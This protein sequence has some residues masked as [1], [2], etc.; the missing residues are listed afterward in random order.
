[1]AGFRKRGAVWYYRYRDETGRQIEAKGCRDLG[2]TKRLAHAAEDRARAIKAGLID[3]REAQYAEAERRPLAEHVGDWHRALIARGR[4]KRYA[5]L[6][7]DYVLRLIGMAKATRIGQLTPSGI[8]IALGDLSL[9]PGRCGN[10]GLSDRSVFHHARAGKM[11]AKWLWKDGRARE[12]RLAHLTAPKVVHARRRAALS[13]EDGAR[14]IAAARA[15]GESYKLSGEDR[16]ILYALAL[17]T[18][19]RANELRSLTPEDFRL[20]TDPPVVVCRAGYAKNRKE[21]VQPIRPDL[22]AMLRP[23]VATRAAGQA[24]FGKLSDTAKM[25]RRDLRAAGLSED[26]D[27]HCLRHTYVTMLVQSGASVKVVQTLARHADPAL[28]LGTYSHV[29]VFDLARGLDALPALAVSP[30]DAEAAAKTGTYGDSLAH[31]LPTNRVSTGRGGSDAV[32]SA[33]SRNPLAPTIPGTVRPKGTQGGESN[34]FPSSELR[35]RGSSPLGCVASGRV[36]W[37]CRP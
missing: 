15:G 19:F 14:L 33:A 31:T 4:V 34:P 23:W 7:R 29:Q 17:G 37:T 12:D 20:D 21:A 8:Q 32:V 11:F 22:A 6:A 25:I 35:V 28:T 2:M 27:F 36:V 26:F 18:G 30:A 13:P 10:A 9:I 1:M 5:D 3:P 16:A 24:V